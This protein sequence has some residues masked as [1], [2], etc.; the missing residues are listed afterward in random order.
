MQSVSPGSRL[1]LLGAGNCNDIDLHGLSQKFAEIHLMDLDAE[2]LTLGV[3]RQGFSADPRIVLHGGVDVTGIADIC[4]TWNS[5]ASPS[6]QELE[7]ATDLAQAYTLTGMSEC[8]DVVAS[9]GLLSQLTEMV[10]QCL[11]TSHAKVMDF[12]AVMRLRHMGLLIECVRPGGRVILV[13]EIVSSSTCPQLSTTS[14]AELADLLRQLINN[15]NFFTG[16]NPVV[17]ESL[18]R[19][20]PVLAPHIEQVELSSPWLW[21]FGPRVYACCALS[22]IRRKD[23]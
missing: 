16:L 22:G 9:V 17:L 8:F 20:S 7:V 10:L 14:A 5:P 6:P 2:A 3:T 13:T 11:G 12:L 21:D 1:L 18:W 19:H 15:R 23:P 4:S